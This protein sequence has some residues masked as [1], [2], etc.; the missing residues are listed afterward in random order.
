MKKP[1]ILLIGIMLVAMGNFTVQAQGRFSKTV[2]KAS[3]KADNATRVTRAS[4]NTGG[5]KDLSLGSSTQKTNGT[6]TSASGSSN[7]HNSSNV[8]HLNTYTRAD[9]KRSAVYGTQVT[10]K[11]GRRHVTGNGAGNQGKGHIVKNTEGK[12]EYHRTMNGRIVVDKKNKK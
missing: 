9:G 10:E 2:G 12:T 11:N 6:T 4:Q 8:I 3:N 5:S 7:K 1:K